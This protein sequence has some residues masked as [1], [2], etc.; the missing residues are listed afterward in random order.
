MFD[1]TKYIPEKIKSRIQI[2]RASFRKSEKPNNGRTSPGKSHFASRN[3]AIRQLKEFSNLKIQTVSPAK[4]EVK[5]KFGLIEN[6]FQPTIESPLKTPSKIKTMLDQKNDNSHY[7]NFIPQKIKEQFYKEHQSD[8]QHKILVF[9]K[10]ET[11]TI[12]RRYSIDDELLFKTNKRNNSSDIKDNGKIK[13]T[14]L[15]SQSKVSVDTSFGSGLSGDSVLDKKKRYDK[16]L[17]SKIFNQSSNIL[18][19]AE[20]SKENN[21]NK[22]TIPFMRRR[23]SILGYS[24]KTYAK[25][26]KANMLVLQ[27]DIEAIKY[28]RQLIARHIPGLYNEI[29]EIPDL[30]GKRRNK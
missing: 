23:S 13:C 17:Q 4:K 25:V 1:Y 12:E 6:P 27:S 20:N 30:S 24:K 2:R 29:L 9:P 18:E 10:S 26:A 16:K 14:D 15:S 28:K 7:H 3:P 21:Q 5:F 11:N 19:Q 22:L 8:I